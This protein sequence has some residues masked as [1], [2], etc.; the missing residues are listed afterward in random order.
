MTQP[1]LLTLADIA[2]RI[3]VGVES[4]RVYHQRATKNRRDGHPRP[5]DLPEPDAVFG[6]SPV[7]RSSTVDRWVDRRPGRG[8]GGGRKPHAIGGNR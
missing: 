7:W 5:G 8:V 1:S 2:D 3:G 4:I 6:R